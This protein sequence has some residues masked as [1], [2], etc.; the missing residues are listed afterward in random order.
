L[1]RVDT[2]SRPCARYQEIPGQIEAQLLLI[3]SFAH[4]RPII[5]LDNYDALFTQPQAEAEI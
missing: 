4:Y 1:T 3:S 5:A 2:V